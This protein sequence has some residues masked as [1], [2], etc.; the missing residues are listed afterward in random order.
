MHGAPGGQT[1]ATLMTVLMIFLNCLVIQCHRDRLAELVEV[2]HSDT[3]W[4]GGGGNTI[5][6]NE[7]LPVT[8]GAP[9]KYKHLLEPFT[10][11]QLPFVGLIKHTSHWKGSTGQERLVVFE[12]PF[13]S[14]CFTSF[15]YYAGT[16]PTT[17][18]ILMAFKREEPKYTSLGGEPGEGKYL[19]GHHAINIW[20]RYIFL[21][22]FGKKWI[23]RNHLYS[24]KNSKLDQ[25]A[26]TRGWCRFLQLQKS[27]ERFTEELKISNCMFLKMFVMPSHKRVPAKIEAENMVFYGFVLYFC[28]RHCEEI[29]ALQEK[30]NSSKL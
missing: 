18:M 30:R 2:S 24:I 21:F 25:H 26:Y 7:L 11:V 23:L 4:T 29:C 9:D 28:Y 15:D 1:G 27:I 14:K 17:W 12:K 3:E 5:R 16:G 22:I 13:D 8:T 10:N 20:N 6:W 19:L